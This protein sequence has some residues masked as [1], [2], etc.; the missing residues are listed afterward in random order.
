MS[1]TL[2]RARTVRLSKKLDKL[3]DAEAARRNMSVSDLLR[4]AAENFV[5]TSEQTA[6]DWCLT[7]ARQKPRGRKD[8]DLIAAY[9]QRHQ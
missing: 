1:D 4:R 6:A 7:V 2:T 3:L 8:S 5:Q 9:D